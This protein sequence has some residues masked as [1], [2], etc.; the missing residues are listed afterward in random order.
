MKVRS[1]VLHGVLYNAYKSQAFAQFYRVK[2][3][4]L[5]NDDVP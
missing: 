3:V 5:H 4:I 1:R 2:N